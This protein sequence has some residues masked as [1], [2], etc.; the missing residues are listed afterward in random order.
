MR[1]TS[2][3][4]AGVFNPENPYGGSSKYVRWA[5]YDNGKWEENIEAI[6]D[7]DEAALPAAFNQL[8]GVSVE[9]INKAFA[10][11]DTANYSKEYNKILSV[12]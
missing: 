5:T 7:V 12:Y 9:A 4:D 8:K 11:V 2:S 10:K 1:F 6:T 3:D